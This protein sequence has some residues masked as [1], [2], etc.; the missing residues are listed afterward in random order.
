VSAVVSDDRSASRIEPTIERELEARKRR[1]GEGRAPFVSPALDEVGRRLSAL[2][3]ATLPA[4]SMVRDLRPLTGGASKQ[5]FLFDL[6]EPGGRERSL[7]LRT[8]LGECLGTPPNFRRESEIQRALRGI[9][10][11]AEVVCV[12]ADGEHF[13]APAIVLERVSGVT[14][15]SEAAGRPSGL[16]MLFPPRRRARLAPAF[17][18]NL[19]RIHRFADAPGSASLGSFE[20]PKTQTREAA[21]GV[22][23]W[24]RRVWEDDAVDD[25]PMVQVAFDW[26]EAVSETISLVHGD[27][28][29]GNFLFDPETDAMTA[30]LDWELARFGDRHEDLG[31]TLSSIN[32]AVDDQGNPFVC[33]LEPRASFLARYGELS[34]LPVD[35]ERLFFYEV[36]AE[37]KVAVIALGIGPR[38]AEARQ[39][40][41]HL[42]NLVFAPL[43]WRSLARLADMRRPRIRP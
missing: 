42:A 9:V 26:L 3:A 14:T 40:H 38:N 22:I 29:S 31:W 21:D 37:L 34:G 4:G 8:A 27:Y 7:V 1:L 2:V 35:P 10:P 6:K 16:G 33:G 43:G 36:F 39:S 30:I 32:G 20:R 13:G 23:A 17:V 25:H 24:W 41:A 28:R 15:P 12:D 19:C 11:V 18:E 5:H